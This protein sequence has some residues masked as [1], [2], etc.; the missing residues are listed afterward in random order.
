MA[1]FSPTPFGGT[2]APAAPAANS[3]APYTVS[4]FASSLRQKFPKGVA[5][6]GTPYASMSDQDL[7]SRVIQKYPVYQSQVS[8]YTPPADP[9]APTTA[10]DDLNTAKDQVGKIATGLGHIF[11]TGGHNVTAAVTSGADRIAAD[12]KNA[13]TL[14]NEVKTAG[15]ELGTGLQTA[16][17]VAG[18]AGSLIG[19]PV[20]AAIK[21]VADR[22]GNSKSLQ[23][24]ASSPEVSG[25]LD[26]IN[27][28][29]ASVND[30]AQHIADNHPQLAANLGAAGNIAT[31]FGGGEAAD[32]AGTTAGKV[33]TATGDAAKAA[34][35]AA[36][37]IVDKAA[38]AVKEAT[39][40]VTDAA[41]NIPDAM[42][43]ARST[44]VVK[45]RVAELEK[46]EASSA[47]VRKVIAQAKA[48]GIDVKSLVANTD[49]LHGAV[50][51]TGTI[52]TTLPG[53]AVEQLN[54]FIQPQED[55][56]SKTLQRE[57]KT[58]PLADLESGINKAID[59]SPLKGGAKIRALNTA[60]Q[61]IEGYKLDAVDA[62]GKPWVE[63]ESEG[64][65]HI[66]LSTVHDAKVDKY[67]NIDYGNPESSKADKI[68]AK[69]LKETVEKNTDSV[70]AKALNAELAQHYTTLNYLEKL[71]GRKV[72]GG[73]LGKYFARTI[74]AVAGAHMGP[75]GAIAGSEG[76]GAVHGAIMG[77]KFGPKIGA[78]MES[79]QAM[80]DAIAANGETAP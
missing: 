45:Q 64:E 41:S 80:K 63:G 40:K 52:R 65:P 62:E 51:K 21:S 79:S 49:L 23:D 57:G 1:I 42:S 39:T 19:T 27:N 10:A 54:D 22:A 55:V 74:G 78:S 24:F 53:G 70:D 20:A 6:D 16:G 3:S 25:M 13:P 11:S 69:E 32:V 28:G 15:D 58:I 59:T 60:K 17:A 46:I 30:V 72:D 9:N 76:A 73:K 31:L 5:S 43:A 37:P 75:L 71:D 66:P 7:T 2:S 68:I 4:S 67:S 33:A 50:D 18:T 12:N 14:G 47:P 8:D 29:V 38:T 34:T 48:K 44:R 26:H 36:A 35:D 77:T 56:I 61:D